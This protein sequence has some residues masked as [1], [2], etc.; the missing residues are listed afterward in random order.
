M[1][2]RSLYFEEADE[3]VI[4]HRIRPHWKQAGK[5]HFV[6]WRQADSLPR[7]ALEQ[8]RQERAAWQRAFGNKA[9]EELTSLQRKNYYQLFHSRVEKWLDAGVGSCLLREDAVRAIVRDA[10]HH[11]N[12]QRYD[13]GTFALAPNHVHVLVAPFTGVDLSDVLHSWKSFT[14]K[15][16]NKATGR[17]SALW[18]AESFDHLVRNEASLANFEE[19]ILAHQ[20]QGAYVEQRTIQ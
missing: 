4:T 14:A 12:G 18:Q 13:L 15:S 2:H 9:L 16:V 17:S 6:T 8:L 20:K 5:I 10:L 19:Y 1:D 7:S 11:F 3:L